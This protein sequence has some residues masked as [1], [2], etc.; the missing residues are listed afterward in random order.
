DM[1]ISCKSKSKIE[2][3]KGLL[4][5]EFKMMELGLARKILGMKIV[6]DRGSRTLK[7]SQSGYVQKIPNNYR[8]DN[9]KR[10]LCY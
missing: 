3:T 9:G 10:S 6:R 2:Y 4:R 8:M 1:L 7:V 5:K